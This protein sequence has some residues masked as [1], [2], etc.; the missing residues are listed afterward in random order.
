MPADLSD[1]V[2]REGVKEME[3]TVRSI[4]DQLIRL[5]ELSEL[6]GIPMPSDLPYTP[7]Y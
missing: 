1:P 3:R 6:L 7:R 2:M 4:H 5:L